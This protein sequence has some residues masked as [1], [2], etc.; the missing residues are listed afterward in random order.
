MKYILKFLSL[1]GLAG[2]VVYTFFI[3]GNVSDYDFWQWV[4]A[5]AI[6]LITIGNYVSLITAAV[7]ASDNELNDEKGYLILSSFLGFLSFIAVVFVTKYSQNHDIEYLICVLL[8]Y[9]LSS[10]LNTR[11]WSFLFLGA[12]QYLCFFEDMLLM[13]TW[14]SWGVYSLLTI[15]HIICIITVIG[16]KM[17]SDQVPKIELSGILI[18]IFFWCYV[19]YV[20]GD[21]YSE[22]NTFMLFVYVLISLLSSIRDETTKFSAISLVSILYLSIF[23]SKFDDVVIVTAVI[24][25]LLGATFHIIYKSRIKTILAYLIAQNC[26]TIQEYNELVNDYNQTI[27]SIREYMEQNTG[28]YSSNTSSNTS[29]FERS[30]ISGAT[31]G[32]ISSLFKILIGE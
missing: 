23:E 24:S 27:N 6:S 16:D 22:M 5:S 4:L 14:H 19:W 25:C 17:D 3:N 21:V 30:A 28:T 10:G 8:A 13:N 15:T 20:N 32:I 7:C 26:Q 2:A 31:S 12:T 11:T 1:T 18:P 9:L 29:D